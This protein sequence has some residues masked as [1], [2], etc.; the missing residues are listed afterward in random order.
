MIDAN[1]FYCSRTIKA[2]AKRRAQLIGTHAPKSCPSKKLH[3]DHSLK[4]QSKVSTYSIQANET[5]R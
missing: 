3:D 5:I 4:T 1:Q 2:M